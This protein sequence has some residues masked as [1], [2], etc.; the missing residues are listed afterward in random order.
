MRDHPHPWKPHVKEGGVRMENKTKILAFAAVALMFAA[1]FIGFVAIND[2]EVDAE[3]ANV[4]SVKIG[5]VT[6]EYATIEEAVEKAQP[7]E[8]GN[9]AT[10]TLLK[11]VTT[12]KTLSFTKSG[13]Y[14][15]DIGEFT[16]TQGVKGYMISVGGSAPPVYPIDTINTSAQI[17]IKGT[18][19]IIANN[20]TFRSYGT[21][22]FGEDGVGPTVT[23]GVEK[24]S[25]SMFKVE[26]GSFLTING[27]TFNLS[28][29][30][31]NKVTR[32]MQNFGTTII[33]NGTFGA[34][35]E[36]WKYE[37]H[38]SS[39]TINGG[40]FNGKFIRACEPQYTLTDEDKIVINGGSYFNDPTS[41]VK[42]GEVK[43]N[44]D[45][46]YSKYVVNPSA[47][48]TSGNQTVYYDS[49]SNAVANAGIDETVKVLRDVDLHRSS[50]VVTKSVTIDLNGK[51]IESSALV[52]DIMGKDVAFT[53]DANGGSISTT[54]VAVVWTNDGKDYT[55]PNVIVKGGIYSGNYVFLNYAQNGSFS[56]DKAVVNGKA[57]GI[58]FG[59]GPASKVSITDSRIV[60]T[61]GIGIYLGTVKEATLSNINVTGETGIEIKSG[62]VSI[63]GHSTITATAK[64]SASGSMGN[65]GSGG[66]VAAICINNAYVDV[67]C[68]EVP[69]T[70]GVFVTIGKDVSI[71][72]K[73]ADDV[74]ICVTSGYKEGSTTSIENAP[75][76]LNAD[77]K[78]GEIYFNYGLEE[79]TT[80]SPI[81]YN[82]AVC[83]MY[84]SMYDAVK[85]NDKVNGYYLPNDVKL[86]IGSA[87][88]CTVTLEE[89]AEL[90]ITKDSIFTETINFANN[91]LVVDKMKA[92]DGGIVI[93]ASGDRFVI[94]GS[95]VSGSMIIE[96]GTVV[97]VKDGG[98]FSFDGIVDNK[99]KIMAAADKFIVNGELIMVAGSILVIDGKTTIGEEAFK[100]V[101]NTA[102]LTIKKNEKGGYDKI[103]SGGS[104]ISE[105][106][107]IV[108]E[109]DTFK[110]AKDSTLTALSIVVAD[111]KDLIVEGKLVM[112][113]GSEL[114]ENG[115]TII[116]K[117]VFELNGN[118]DVLMINTNSKGGF[119]ATLNG[120]ATA[121]KLDVWIN[122]TFTVA[123]GA[124]LT[125]AGTFLNA[126]NV[127]IDGT[128]L[129][130]DAGKLQ[131]MK[132]GIVTINGT[133]DGGII[134]ITNV[135]KDIVCVLFKPNSTITS[136]IDGTD[137]GKT[138]I[139]V[140]FGIKAG[141]GGVS[142]TKGSVIVD[143]ALVEG[144][145]TVPSGSTSF[146][147][148]TLEPGATLTIENNAAVNPTG[149]GSL[150]VESG[151]K[152]VTNNGASIKSVTYK[153][154]S[155]LNGT[156]F[157][158]DTRVT[159]EGNV[160]V[161]IKI[162]LNYDNK[163][164]NVSADYVEAFAGDK[165][166]DVLSGVT[167]SGVNSRI[168]FSG[169][170]NSL[171]EK[172][173]SDVVVPSG[174]ADVILTAHFTEKAKNTVVNTGSNDGVDYSVVIAFIVLIGS[175]VFLCSV[176][177]KR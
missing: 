22:I 136:K 39:I 99:G 168:T 72:P 143:G 1:C 6:K 94:N 117:D 121:S 21:M 10:I 5:D 15:L 164:L 76:F 51:K 176:L 71:V 17:T 133:I 90:T 125:M 82:G 127:T 52:F 110:I 66:S 74:K 79:G 24:D 4:A 174:G 154:G 60:A 165:Y 85:D 123:K 87:D 132:N 103:L 148:G 9:I 173:T 27:G 105:I 58:W 55:N 37:N 157:D 175:I 50:V 7:S 38:V 129:M 155:E 141:K 159:P 120:K 101:D 161:A 116:G 92:G 158:T 26:E 42:D 111:A 73:D 104:A 167:V 83:V 16:L 64:F 113:H 96:K 137:D 100:F 97:S 91:K 131:V 54:G 166:V 139:V 13:Q 46:A 112:V 23:I 14:T 134:D 160:L 119:D 169:W 88:G 40:T 34:D 108:G 80:V 138:S 45:G 150:V 78:M 77:L 130:T 151:A 135:D 156:T 25:H 153:A 89:R 35:I 152:V 140:L 57:A 107:L 36:L 44:P 49:V 11:N 102:F 53:I 2:G 106:Q 177:R 63:D 144:D 84:Q 122:D 147:Y 59:N 98:S 12:T 8:S 170:Y 86:S 145:V 48:I 67:V 31:S 56:I 30:P 149:S 43:T 65:S 109:K 126:G 68:S 81:I 61:D 28:S 171:D 118:D 114:I 33:N 19:N 115:K 95:S 163:K 75:I 142:V 70:D 162:Y 128:L 20:T 18:G 69:R 93:S 124:E 146:V 41:F 172:I 62:T 3:G 47:S 32:L 29:E